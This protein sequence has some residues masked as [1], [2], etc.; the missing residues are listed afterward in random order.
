MLSYDLDKYLY[1]LSYECYDEDG[2]RDYSKQ[3]EIIN[4]TMLDA[5]LLNGRVS[6]YSELCFDYDN[7]SMTSTIW[8]D[9]KDVIKYNNGCK[10][11]PLNK[12]K[13]KNSFINYN[14]CE[15]GNSNSTHINDIKNKDNQTD[16]TFSCKGYSE[17][18]VEDMTSYLVNLLPHEEF[19]VEITDDGMKEYER[20]TLIDYL[21][22]DNLFM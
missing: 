7:S 22:D 16:K 21:K 13:A 14:S 2:F 5:K 15:C 4:K 19:N 17:H 20:E 8:Y 1:I 3:S 12:L 6:N 11:I 18:Y 9:E 10:F